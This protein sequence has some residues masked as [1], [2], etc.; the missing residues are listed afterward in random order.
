MRPKKQNTC[1]PTANRTVRLRLK[2]LREAV[3]GLTQERL[4]RRCGVSRVY[5]RAIETGQRPLTKSIA[6]RISVATGVS[7]LWLMGYQ[8]DDSR[9]LDLMH[10]EYSPQD[11]MNK[12]AVIRI[13]PMDPDG[14]AS[15][16]IHEVCHE[17]T[18]LL[19]AAHQKGRFGTALFL[20][21]QLVTEIIE[22]AGLKDID[23][24]QLTR[25]QQYVFGYAGPHKIREEDD[26][27]EVDILWRLLS[28]T[29]AIKWAAA[30][31]GAKE[32][33]NYLLAEL[34]RLR[35]LVSES[36]LS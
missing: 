1:I 11:Y 16:Q 26:P 13:E 36:F 18:N 4:A 23:D 20:F 12:R 2:A 15:S 31:R 35:D 29:G 27:G 17:L 7:P 22:T 5:I 6:T 28:P 9:P 30:F 8:G 3:D 21:R 10:Q 33:R 32:E 24:R 25:L 19:R 34:D 14:E